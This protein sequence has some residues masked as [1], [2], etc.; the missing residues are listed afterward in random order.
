MD[1]DNFMFVYIAIG[2]HVMLS[3]SSTSRVRKLFDG[4]NFKKIFLV[5]IKIKLGYLT[6]E[7]IMR[8]ELASGF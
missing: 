4:E 7:G 8:K 1:S 5:K 3:F 6:F 2:L